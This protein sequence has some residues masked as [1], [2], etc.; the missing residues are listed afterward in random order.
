MQVSVSCRGGCGSWWLGMEGRWGSTLGVVG[1]YLKMCNT[2]TKHVLTVLS[3]C[4]VF[5]SIAA[6]SP[7]LVTLC[8]DDRRA[9]TR[10]SEPL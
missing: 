7:L 6:A 8:R 4:L 9:E 2:C 10:I 1:S 5:V 3:V